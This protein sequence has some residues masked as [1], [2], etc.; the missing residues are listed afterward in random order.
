MG[1]NDIKY[2]IIENFQLNFNNR[3]NS[4]LC[5]G[6]VS[7]LKKFHNLKHQRL[8]N[9]HIYKNFLKKKN[10]EHIV[11][12][13]N[14]QGGQY[15]HEIIPVHYLE[16]QLYIKLHIRIPFTLFSRV[17]NK[18]EYLASD[19]GGDGFS[20]IYGKQTFLNRFKETLIAITAKKAIIVLP[21]T[22][23][24]FSSQKLKTF[25]EKILR[26]ATKI[27]VRDN[28]FD[29]EMRKMNIPYQL[30][31]DLSAFMQPEPW[32]IS[33]NKRY[34]IGL[35]ISGLA[36]SGGWKG[37]KGQFKNYPKLI[38][39]IIDYF[40][41]EGRTIY[42]IPHSYNYDN[43]EPNNDDL[44]AC[45]SVYEKRTNKNNII[46]INQNLTAPQIKYVI[47]QMSFFIGTRMH[48]NFAAIFSKVPVFG[49]AY[50][51]KFQGAFENNG[52]YDQTAMINNISLNQ[53]NDIVNHIIKVYKKYIQY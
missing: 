22:L 31:N 30:T 45:K 3:G 21:Q 9:F 41:K 14:I 7:F 38:D 49:L 23:G 13:L 5:Y 16:Y 50:S 40:Q 34:A 44:I 39:Q 11:E 12:T 51:Y 24:P 32:D 20:D 8:L 53:I 43:P 42:L 36:Y 1:K 27:Y 18:I 26:Y 2:I 19:Y 25:G 28:Q 46:F 10:L 48:A 17:I 33:I 35:N 29:Y 6:A 37:T 52:I 4:A 47:S 15:E